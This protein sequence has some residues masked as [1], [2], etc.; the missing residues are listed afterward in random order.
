MTYETYVASC[1][2]YIVM[3]CYLKR[4][5]FGFSALLLLED[6]SCLP[7]IKFTKAS[8]IARV[9]KREEKIL[10]LARTSPFVLFSTGKNTCFCHSC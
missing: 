5:P 7:M 8:R 10:E 4:S 1:S 9:K 2:Q 6:G 3:P